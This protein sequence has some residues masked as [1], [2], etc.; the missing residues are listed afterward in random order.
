[1]KGGDEGSSQNSRI[2]S[3]LEIFEMPQCLKKEDD[4]PEIDQEFDFEMGIRKLQA[5]Q[6]TSKDYLIS[7]LSSYK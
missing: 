2:H 5:Y 1:M 4:I 7:A 3:L 6:Q